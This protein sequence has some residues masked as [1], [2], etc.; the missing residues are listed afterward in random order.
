[1]AT[2]KSAGGSS[3][4]STAKCS[5]RGNPPA[6]QIEALMKSARVKLGAV[7]LASAAADVERAFDLFKEL[8]DAKER[9]G[10]T[11]A[12]AGPLCSLMALVYSKAR[13]WP[14]VYQCTDFAL[15]RGVGTEDARLDL[16]LRH[17]IAL[18]H[19]ACSTWRGSQPPEGERLA[20]AEADFVDV[21]KFRSQAAVQVGLE[22]VAFLRRQATPLAPPGERLIGL[23]RLRAMDA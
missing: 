15:K 11:A 3:R 7:D 16:K 20:E 23:A 13:D 19:L 12:N 2:P 9:A 21:S 5:A 1:M 8:A 17:G 4:T 10:Q 22:Q 18:S 6:L 14:K